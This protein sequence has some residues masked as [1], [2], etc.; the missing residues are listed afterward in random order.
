[1]PR[2]PHSSRSATPRAIA[3]GMLAATIALTP[4]APLAAQPPTTAP[5]DSSAAAPNIS[6]R[7]PREGL[8]TAQ[9]MTWY[10]ATS[11]VKGLTIDGKRGGNLGY[12][13]SVPKGLDPAK[14]GDLIIVMHPSGT[15]RLWATRSLPHAM[16]RSGN[17]IVVPDAVSEGGEFDVTD[18]T[19]AWR[20]RTS[21][22][23]ALRD[24]ILDV[25]RQFPTGQI[26]LCGFG[27]GGRMSIAFLRSFPRL[28][29]G[30]ASVSGGVWPESLI[31]LPDL[32]HPVVMVHR[33]DDRSV[34]YSVSQDAQSLLS[35]GGWSTVRL[36]RVAPLDDAPPPDPASPDASLLDG[37]SDAIDF[38]AGMGTESA[39]DALRAARALARASN[40]AGTIRALGAAREVLRRFDPK[41][42]IRALKDIQP[43]Q[44]EEAFALAVEIEAHAGEHIR[45]IAATLPK[46]PDRTLDNIGPWAGHILAVRDALFGTDSW[47]TFESDTD[48]A[49]DLVNHTEASGTILEAWEDSEATPQMR[50]RAV[51]STLRTTFMSDGLPADM[52]GFCIRTS[53]DA[54][55]LKISPEDAAKIAGVQAYARAMEAG[56]ERARTIAR[57]W[58]PSERA[59]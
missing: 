41:S 27:G 30:V 4:A 11:R 57:S 33:V 16:F 28:V 15:D 25:A 37:A 36:Q 8:D 45:A 19:R 17:I 44:R 23:T 50:Y 2:A 21:D 1:M 5:A 55:A 9:P 42:G 7:S 32:I 48:L 53:A 46:R 43:E 56:A 34:P 59:R 12:L 22:V 29:T 58:R 39:A 31:Q 49:I 20:Q 52:V 14:P 10:Q 51:I 3:L 13:W 26:I 40:E 47:A 6:E 24:F 18:G 35:I 38:I 54:A